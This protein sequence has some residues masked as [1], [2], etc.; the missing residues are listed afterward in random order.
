MRKVNIIEPAA[1]WKSGG[2]PL[3][4]MT[5][6]GDCHPIPFFGSPCPQLP[7]VTYHHFIS[8]SYDVHHFISR[9]ETIVLKVIQFECPWKEK[10]VGFSNRKF[11]VRSLLHMSPILPRWSN[12]TASVVKVAYRSIRIIHQQQRVPHKR[13]LRIFNRNL[14]WKAKEI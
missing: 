7:V 1:R 6:G 12:M 3:T 9:N 14:S 10:I 2:D 8:R 13:K 4:L 11:Y 5:S